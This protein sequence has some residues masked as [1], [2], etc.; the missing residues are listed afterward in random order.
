MTPLAEQ[1]AATVRPAGSIGAAVARRI[2]L[3]T[4]ANFLDKLAILLVQLVSIPVLTH[5]WGAEGYGT[6]LMLMTL[7]TYLALTDLGLGAAASVDLAHHLARSDHEQA[8][9][10]LTTWWALVTSMS[11][12]AVI[13]G[14]MI[15][16][17]VVPIDAADPRFLL[18]VLATSFYG[19]VTIQMSM[20]LRVYGATRRYALSGLL[21]AACFA[22][23]GAALCGAVYLGGDH[24]AAA[25]TLALVRLLFATVSWIALRRLETRLVFG[26]AKIRLEVVRRLLGPSA[27]SLALL[28]GNAV[29]LQGTVLVLGWTAGPA[30]A[31]I[32][33]ATRFLCRIPLQFSF[34][35]LRPSLTEMTYAAALRDPKGMLSILRTNF[36]ASAIFAAVS[37]PLLTLS[38]PALTAELTNG[39]LECPWWLFLTVAATASLASLWPVIAAPLSATNRHGG[40]ALGFL[41]FWVISILAA[42]LVLHAG[43]D[44]LLTMGL[45][46]L[47]AELG[48]ALWA[49]RLVKTG[50]AT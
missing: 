39:A 30:V 46:G 11:G 32:F 7:P 8:V 2:G 14:C 43:F 40:V 37:V 23:E 21:S 5:A 22:C 34:L 18:A 49:R 1:D 3:G 50:A 4:A 9:V 36:M 42:V 47:G 24:L 17:L 28:L 48:T 26:F 25:C 16:A 19:V 29:A 45:A 33:A 20:A 35:L 27:A 15:C 10:S 13:L 38:G 12:I 6:W 41:L 31:A 44:P